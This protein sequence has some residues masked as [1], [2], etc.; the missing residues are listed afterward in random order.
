MSRLTCEL[1]LDSLGVHPDHQKKGIGRMLLDWGIKEASKQGKECYLVATPAGLPLYR[2][3]GFE[4]VR[5]LD[6]FGTPHVSMRR[7][8]K[9]GL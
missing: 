9:K 4:D 2:S 8:S 6:I 1:A 3:A 5:V 7:A